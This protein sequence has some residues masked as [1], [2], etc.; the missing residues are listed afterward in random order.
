MKKTNLFI[1][2]FSA[3][4]ALGLVIWQVKNLQEMQLLKSETLEQDLQSTLMDVAIE[5]RNKES[6]GDVR[7]LDEDKKVIAID[8]LVKNSF[9][10]FNSALFWGIY[11]DD[12]TP[13]LGDYN[14]LQKQKLIETQYKVCLSC[15]LT[16]DF[17]KADNSEENK[18]NI[19]LEHSPAQIRAMRG[20]PHKKL[21]YL[22]FFMDPI[23]LGIKPYILPLLFLVSLFTILS[24]LLYL[25]LIQSR[26][27]KQKNEFVNHLSH[28]FQTPLSSIKLSANLL[29]NEDKLDKTELVRIIQTESKRLENHI[30][31]VLHW[32]KSDA[33][34]L[35][36]LKQ[37]IDLEKL[38]KESI[39]QMKPIFISNKTE[40]EYEIQ[41]E[42][43]M[44][45]ADMNHIQLVLF[46]IWENAIKH[47][48]YPIKLKVTCSVFG[49]K[50]QI[51]N[52]DNGK[53]FDQYFKSNNFKGLGLIYVKNIMKQHGGSLEIMNNS[54]NGASINLNF[55]SNG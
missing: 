25:T 24:Y 31:T 33:K 45:N 34:R 42:Q 23:K 50:I 44:I 47:N 48:E 18:T 30:K 21:N 43:I 35:Q 15:L 5:L 55:P 38:I 28:Q 36:I 1:S 4:I 53:G 2:I 8:S 12:K 26:L 14:D 54:T 19:L 20:N 39:N 27:I 32:V 3:I 51:R 6:S 37:Q 49:D 17:P 11:D 40:I 10:K 9:E 13:L 46:N 29:L 41:S 16:I 7:F 52:I 22:H